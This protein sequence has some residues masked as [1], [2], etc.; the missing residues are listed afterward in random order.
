MTNAVTRSGSPERANDRTHQ[1]LRFSCVKTRR[2]S[3]VT[4]ILALTLCAAGAVAC[5]AST[6][7]DVTGSGDDAQ[8][9]SEGSKTGA[10]NANTG[11]GG[12]IIGSGA[13]TTD[14]EHAPTLTGNTS[15]SGGAGDVGGLEG[16]ACATASKAVE[17]PPVHLVFMI[18]RSGSMGNTKEAGN[19]LEVRW[20]P[21]VAGLDA[22]FADAANSNVSASL[23]YF[24]QGIS[25]GSP[26]GMECDADTYAKPAVSMRQ[27][28]D[29]NA[30]SSALGGVEPQGGTPTKPALQGAIA[31]AQQIKASLPAGEKVA[32]VLATDG[33]PNDC[34]STA[35][36]VADVAAAVKAQIP[37]YVIGVGPDTTKLDTIAQGGG[38]NKAIMIKTANPA[39]VSADLRKAVGQIKAEQLGCSYPLPTPPDG[40]SL[41]VNAVN[42][43]F[44]PANGKAQTLAYSAD[45]TNANGWHYDSTSAPTEVVMCASSCNTLKAGAGKVDIVF[46]CAIE[47]PPGT[48]L[49]GGGVR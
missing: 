32:I 24:A 19:N 23:A 45:C 49:P 17:A 27:L 10:N 39:Q 38:T 5:G 28:P 20:K 47:A 4:S 42:V 6:D 1:G 11:T 35:E 8:G 41:D 36:N 25:K 34:S 2:F 43:D 30:F 15:S 26:K 22:F 12:S 46:G 44:T 37:T 3:L 40:K 7:G 21:V 18:D 16:E 48:Q 9:A 33:D 31:Y 29:A 14:L 13:P